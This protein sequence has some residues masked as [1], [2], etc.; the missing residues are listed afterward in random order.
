[1]IYMNFVPLPKNEAVVGRPCSAGFG[2]LHKLRL[3][4]P[5]VGKGVDKVWG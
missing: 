5:G 4:T 2:V 3:P 1:M